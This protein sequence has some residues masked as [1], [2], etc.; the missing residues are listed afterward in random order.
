MIKAFIKRSKRKLLHLRLQPIHVYCFHQVSDS[1]DS[2]TMWECDWS[3]TEV[4]KQKVLSLKAKYSFV[5][6][7]E[8]YRHIV[9]DRIRIRR[10]AALTADDGW[11]SLNHILPWL[12]EHKIPI[13][14][15][16]NPLYF[17]GVHKQIREAE[18]LLTM[19]E[20]EQ[21]VSRYA[22]Y[23]SIASHGWS[24]KDCLKMS[25]GEFEESVC[26]AD[27]VLRFMR[28]YIPFY[29][30]TYGHHNDGQISFLHN[31]GLIPVIMNG[32]INYRSRIISREC[33]DVGYHS[34]NLV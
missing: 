23:V 10:Y 18:K 3:Q 14:L 28:G 6:L 29:A 26:N 1:F 24:H 5:S 15:F 4:F 12:F 32:K 19:E 9:H 7:T 2:N 27:T 8:A 20:V 17:D 30:F 21:I 34:V 33:I 22:P 25:M 13:T 11:E 31:K 16:L